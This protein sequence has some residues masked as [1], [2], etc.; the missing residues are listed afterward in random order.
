MS[1][2]PPEASKVLGKLGVSEETLRLEKG[3]KK[4][5]VCD[6]DLETYKELQKHSAVID[7]SKEELSKEE[8]AMGYCKKQMDRVKAVK[9]LGTTE[10]EIIEDHAHRVSQLGHQVSHISVSP[11]KRRSSIMVMLPAKWSQPQPPP[12]FTGV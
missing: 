8:R 6:N 10:E 11:R 2:I 9:N 4:L 12:Q 5:G 1:V 7:L 3:M